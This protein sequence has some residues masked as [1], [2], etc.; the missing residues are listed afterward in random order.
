[1]KSKSAPRSAP[2]DLTIHF[3]DGQMMRWAP[4]ADITALEVCQFAEAL[5]KAMRSD[6][7]RRSEWA[8]LERHLEPDE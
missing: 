7:V 8:G 4:K 2:R 5:F 6:V 1:M 3:E